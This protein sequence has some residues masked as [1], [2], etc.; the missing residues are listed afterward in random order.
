M[1]VLTVLQP[2]GGLWPCCIL[3]CCD[4]GHAHHAAPDYN[5]ASPE[6]HTYTAV[7]EPGGVTVPSGTQLYTPM[8]AATAGAT[9]AMHLYTP[10]DGDMANRGTDQAK[11]FVKLNE[12]GSNDTVVDQYAENSTGCGA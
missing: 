9:P 6:T 12:N 3:V 4:P 11:P 8:D 10:A 1:L 2:N 5:L 7:D